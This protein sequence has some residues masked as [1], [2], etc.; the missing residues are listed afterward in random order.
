MKEGVGRAIL[1]AIFEEHGLSMVEDVEVTLGTT[2][3]VLD[4]WDEAR[5]VGYEVLTSEAGDRE[6]FPP[7]VVAELEA[8]MRR[9]EATILLVDLDP[10][11]E[12]LRRAAEGFLAEL[13]KRGALP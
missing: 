5:R 4:G 2:T 8:A 1:R 13:K 6:A 7:E 10:S 11:E 3:V 12:L 9:G